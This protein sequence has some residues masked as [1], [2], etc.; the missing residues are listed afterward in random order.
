M[1]AIMNY[2]KK[3]VIIIPARMASSRYPNKPLCKIRGKSMI[4]RVY[5]IAQA[6][7][8]ASKVLIATDDLNLKSH[9]EQFGAEV[10]LTSQTCKTGTDR[11]A[12]AY[13]ILQES[14]DII[15]N[16]QGDAVLTPPW[17]IDALLKVMLDN[18]AIETATPVVKLSGEALV[19]FVLKKK[20]GSSSGTCC[21]F[22]KNNDALYFSKTLIPY[23]RENAQE[24]QDYSIYQH[25][26]L[27]AYTPAALKRW[28]NLEQTPLE[29]IEQLEQLRLLENGFKI[30]VVPVDYQNRSHGSVDNPEDVA[31]IEAIIDKE[32]ELVF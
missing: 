27:Y 18:P 11:L 10:I 28:T 4:E 13:E 9:A 5:R 21:V 15:F 8:Y 22:D 25:I 31:F 24:A 2:F 17:I 1:M 12:Q 29:K 16:L 30:R 14:Y 20:K 7:Q 32:G 6:S 23:P 3:A 26:G 19:K